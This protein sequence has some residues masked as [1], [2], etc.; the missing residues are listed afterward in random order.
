M[1]NANTH[2]KRKVRLILVA[3]LATIAI[4]TGSIF[5]FFSDVVDHHTTI[6]AGSLDLVAGQTVIKQNGT[7]ATTLGDADGIV[8]NFNP[9]DV[10]TFTIP[11]TNE[12]SKSAWLRGKLELTGSAVEDATNKKDFTDDFSIFAGEL[13]Q[14]QAE[15]Q[16]G[17]ATDLAVDAT[18]F[19]FTTGTSAVWVDPTPGVINGDNTKADF[20]AEKLTT[21]GG[22]VPT[23]TTIYN[24]GTKEN[25]GTLTYTIYFKT[26]AL[27]KWQNKVLDIDYHAQA[28][29]YRNNP[30]SATTWDDL[31]TSAYG[32]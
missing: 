28:I 23:G 7:D 29:Q 6:T 4:V 21:S 8:E 1:T 2:N 30:S 3:L 31:V 11:V 9:G 24:S 32:N 19:T 27:N 14:A 20:E 25:E 26:S 13:D 16:K 10:V 18:N 12:G 17:S 22:T 15:A 5:A